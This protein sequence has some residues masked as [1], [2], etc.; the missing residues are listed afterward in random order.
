[1]IKKRLKVKIIV[2]KD[3]KNKIIKKNIRT[4]D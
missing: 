1:M 4:K 3:S 2:E